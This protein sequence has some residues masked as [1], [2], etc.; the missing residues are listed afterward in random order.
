MTDKVYSIRCEIND[1][2]W[3]NVQH[4]FDNKEHALKHMRN[5]VAYLIKNARELKHKVSIK[6]FSD[7]VIGSE[8]ESQSIFLRINDDI[9]DFRVWSSDQYNELPK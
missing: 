2:G 8:E 1:G 9:F 7:T 3:N 5:H 6:V 4:Y